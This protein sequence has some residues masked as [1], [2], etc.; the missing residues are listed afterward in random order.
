MVGEVVSEDGKDESYFIYTHKK[1]IITYN[2]DR[3][4]E[5]NLTSENPVQ[6]PNKNGMAITFSYSVN[7]YPTDI[8]FDRRFEKYLDYNFFEHQVSNLIF[9]SLIS[10]PDSLVLD[11]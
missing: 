3:I 2:G 5:V 11:L 6:L 9:T 8:P 1:F 7:W 4:I 10:P